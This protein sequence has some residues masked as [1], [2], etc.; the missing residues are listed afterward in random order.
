[1]RKPSVQR[2]QSSSSSFSS[3]SSIPLSYPSRNSRT[4]TRTSRLQRELLFAAGLLVAGTLVHGA[5]KLSLPPDNSGFKAGPGSEIAMVQCVLCHSADYV[6]TQPRLP[7]AAWKAN[8]LK[9]RDKYGAPL[10]DDKVEAL[11]D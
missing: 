8:V 4:R 6:S 9:M 7:R 3:S 5:E 2:G 11:V 10:P 1:M